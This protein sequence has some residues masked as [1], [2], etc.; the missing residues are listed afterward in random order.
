MWLPTEE[1]PRALPPL[2]PS[3]GPAPPAPRAPSRCW[4]REGTW[5]YGSEGCSA[6]GTRATSRPN[7]HHPSCGAVFGRVTHIVRQDLCKLSAKGPLPAPS[8]A[9]GP[10]RWPTLMAVSSRTW[11]AT[12]GAAGLLAPP[13]RPSVDS[14][15][16]GQG[17]RPACICIITL[18]RVA[19]R[20]GGA[21]LVCGDGQGQCSMINGA[22]AVCLSSGGFGKG[23]GRYPEAREP[24][25]WLRAVLQRTAQ[26]MAGVHAVT[27]D[28][29]ASFSLWN[30][31]SVLGWSLPHHRAGGSLRA[32]NQAHS[33]LEDNARLPINMAV[34]LSSRAPL[35]SSSSHRR[36]L[37]PAFGSVA[38]TLT[39][40]RVPVASEQRVPGPCP[41]CATAR[42]R[43][44]PG[45]GWSEL[46]CDVVEP[47][48]VH[49]SQ[50]LSEKHN[51]KVPPALGPGDRDGRQAHPLS[52]EEETSEDSPPEG[53][54]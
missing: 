9:E 21:R 51:R 47:A 15:L 22:G 46:R 14:W 10:R 50:R 52:L 41:A 17:W 34:S 28:S 18:G 42:R 49:R 40:C 39:T 48:H 24:S 53:G 1:P 54:H 31:F 5:A 19:W 25:A 35:T 37:S 2:C 11:L 33:L 38:P 29:G 30:W 27:G 26:R 44:Q 12:L 20:T 43:L 23:S 3:P 13:V 32:K 45:H 7:S 36:E 16:R 6:S 8:R 4:W